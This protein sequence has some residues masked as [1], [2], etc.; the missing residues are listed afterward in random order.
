M[1]ALWLGA[2]VPWLSGIEHQRVGLRLA[3]SA[4]TTL[5]ML[6]GVVVFAGFINWTT[7]VRSVLPAIPAAALIIAR[8]ADERLGARPFPGAARVVV[9]LSLAIA[10]WVAWGD[11][12]LARAQVR[13]AEIVRNTTASHRGTLW[14]Q[15]HWG[16]QIAMEAIGAQ[17]TDTV[18]SR[19]KLGDVV[20]VPLNNTNRWPLP[21]E[22]P[23][24][25]ERF[26]VP[27]G[28]GGTTICMRCGAG[29][30][31][32]LWGP[33]PYRL[34]PPSPERYVIVSIEP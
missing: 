14:F 21:E 6:L 1:V 2:T 16:F 15:G 25:L 10:L 28:I 23:V 3:A 33:L 19:F 8:A 29:F 18:T 11:Y 32:S 12:A 24:R 34:E 30:Y 13:A 5:C 9:G 27:I 22:L 20:V 31:S 17:P 7:N 4:M 26:E